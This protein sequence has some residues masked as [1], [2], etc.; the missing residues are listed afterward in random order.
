[1]ANTDQTHSQAALR[2]FI[3]CDQTDTAPIWGYMIREKGLVAILETSV[4]RA[5]ERAVEDIPD[6]IIIDVNASHEERIALCKKLRRGKRI[7]VEPRRETRRRIY[8]PLVGCFH[9]GFPSPAATGCQ[10]QSGDPDQRGVIL[11]RQPLLC[12]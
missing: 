2:V 5:M 3:V 11:K 12:L 8:K 9:V 7:G 10:D 4:Q 6:L 1:M